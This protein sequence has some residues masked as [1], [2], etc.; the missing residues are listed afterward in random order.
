MVKAADVTADGRLLVHGPRVPVLLA[1]RAMGAEAGS[2]SHGTGG[3]GC[4][5]HYRPGGDEMPGRTEVGS[6]GRLCP[7]NGNGAR[8][9][10]AQ[11]HLV[12]GEPGMSVGCLP[13]IPCVVRH[14]CKRFPGFTSGRNLGNEAATRRNRI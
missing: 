9:S 6:R 2:A 12:W 4:V 1:E 7:A 11:R 5:Y 3:R 13:T 14:T 8:Y 10:Y